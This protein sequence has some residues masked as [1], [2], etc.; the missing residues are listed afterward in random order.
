LSDHVGATRN[1]RAL[2]AAG[3]WLQGEAVDSDAASWRSVLVNVYRYAFE[4]WRP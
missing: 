2:E 3:L 4:P 1:P